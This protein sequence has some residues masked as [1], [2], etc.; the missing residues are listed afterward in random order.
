MPDGRGMSAPCPGVES[1]AERRRERAGRRRGPRRRHDGRRHR[2]ARVAPRARARSCTTPTRTRSSAASR[3][4]ASGSSAR[5][6]RGA[7]RRAR[8]G[9]SRR[10]RTWP[11][12]PDAD[13]VIEAAPESLELKRELFGQVA[14]VVRA[15]CVL[16]TNTS[17]LSVTEIAAGVPRPE[18]V[19]GM[20]FFNPAP[21]MKLVEVVAGERSG[22]G[23][24]RDDARARPGD[25]PARDR[26]IRRPR[27]PRQ[28]LR[29]AVRARGA[30]ARAGGAGDPRAGRPR[31]PPRRRLPDGA[32][33]ADGP[34]GDRR[35]LRGLEVLL[36]PVLRRAALAPVDARRA[37]GRLRQPRPQ[38]R[39]RL[40]RVPRGRARTARRTRPLRRRAAA[41][42][43]SW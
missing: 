21:V 33:R 27:L 19:V 22:D 39:A 42:G 12:S 8:Q 23:G 4:S 40:V 9:R 13:V 43:G 16:A 14:E 41:T 26:R 3:A 6:R 29:A 30:A 10:P 5:S 34:R 1:R 32:V 35:R 25:G 38:D 20:H 36:R 37:Q 15:D 28:P 31:L 11:R 2:A 24:A 17:S 7:W 18:R